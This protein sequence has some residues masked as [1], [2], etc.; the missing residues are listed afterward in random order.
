MRQ[1]ILHQI[2][3]VLLVMHFICG[4][5]YAADVPQISTN[6]EL[7]NQVVADIADEMNQT[8]SIQITDTLGIQYI[9]DN[10]PLTQ[11][12]Y[13]RLI[14]DLS[15]NHNILVVNMTEKKH[16][17][18]ILFLQPPSKAG[19]KYI[20][21]KNKVFWK[22]TL[23]ER[24]AY[25]EITAR[26]QNNKEPAQFLEIKKNKVDIVPVRMK[27]YIEQQSMILGPVQ[28]PK[29]HQRDWVETFVA[30]FVSSVIIYL[31]YIIRSE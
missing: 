21:L 4:A 2:Q 27:H 17:H 20:R 28:M 7:L 29:R 8:R 22:K 15:R 25:I 5:F 13:E 31:F 14:L 12:I 26:F 1:G 23:I 6:V 24:Q 30:V 18:A 19:V 10:N 11:Y 3:W 9:D 16:P